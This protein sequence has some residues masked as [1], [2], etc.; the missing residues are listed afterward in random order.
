MT[1]DHTLPAIPLSAADEHRWIM[2]AHLSGLL[3]FIGPL[4][5]WLVYRDRS[6]AVEREAKE[7][8]NAQIT[9]AAVALGLYV[10]GAVLTL[11]LIGFVFLLAAAIV[12]LVALVVAI[13][14]AVR[15]HSA[16]RY[17]YPFTYRVVS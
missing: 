8:L 10:L 2:L 9:L 7:A 4:V 17:R 11:V 13:V 12:Q 6:D 3:S 1:T 14:G 5:V 16:G 15:A